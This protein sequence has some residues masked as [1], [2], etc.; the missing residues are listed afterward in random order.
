MN[1]AKCFGRQRPFLG[2]PSRATA[3][4]ATTTHP[5]FGPDAASPLLLAP[6]IA[7]GAAESS[8]P[9]SKVHNTFYGLVTAAASLYWTEWAVVLPWIRAALAP[10]SVL[11]IVDLAEESSSWDGPL[12]EVI[13]R[14]ST[15]RRFRP[16]D[17]VA[18]LTGS[19]GTR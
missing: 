12:H 18:E 6:P 11:A 15:N 9:S 2:R 7:P 19:R 1:S 4:D 5:A 10:G 16:Y 14:Y 8:A 3:D 13:A 17:L